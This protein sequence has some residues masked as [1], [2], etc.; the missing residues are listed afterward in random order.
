MF[1]K[2][3]I[4]IFFTDSIITWT[5][6][7]I[8]IRNWRMFIM[9]KKRKYI[10]YVRLSQQK[11]WMQIETIRPN[12]YLNMRQSNNIKPIPYYTRALS[13][14]VL[15]HLAVTTMFALFMLF[16]CQ[17][18]TSGTIDSPNQIY[19]KLCVESLKTKKKSL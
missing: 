3:K 1:F 16:D 15:N 18:K 13:L 14:C 9:H 10:F 11:I 19:G 6:I 4:F 8:D 2:R 5:M 7:P 12:V 17:W